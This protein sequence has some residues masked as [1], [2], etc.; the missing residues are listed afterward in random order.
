LGHETLVFPNLI[1]VH[2]SIPSIL[3]CSIIIA[4]NITRGLDTDLHVVRESFTN[5]VRVRISPNQLELFFFW[6]NQTLASPHLHA[7]HALHI[8]YACFWS[9]SPGSDVT[10]MC[11]QTCYLTA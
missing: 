9:H 5:N 1:H 4:L 7:F 8:Y 3:V 10:P 2:A 6:L 11:K